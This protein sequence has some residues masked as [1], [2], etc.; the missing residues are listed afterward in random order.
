MNWSIHYEK[1]IRKRRLERSEGYTESHH[2][3]PIS[4]G[5]PDIPANRVRLTAKEHFLA[6]LLLAKMNPDHDGLI[7]A[8]FLMSNR[9]KYGSRK[10]S[11]LKEKHSQM[12]SKIRQGKAL[13]AATRNK[14]SRV[15]RG[16]LK[17]EEHSKNI[18]EGLKIFMTSLKGIA[19]KQK[20]S[21]NR[22]VTNATILI[23]P[24][25]SKEGK[26]SGMRRWHFDHC[27]VFE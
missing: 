18:S 12:M 1:L 17:S 6:H 2:I 25:C 3:H 20:S 15:R 9:K 4:Q 7:R 27:E 24:H 16:K 11:W 26:S 5:G 14:M 21:L 10:Y 19:Q 8:A 23:C 13:S 22:K